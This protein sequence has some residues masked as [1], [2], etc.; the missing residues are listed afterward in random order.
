MPRIAQL[1]RVASEQSTYGIK[2]TFKD[3]D[4]VLLSASD[5]TSLHWWLTDTS[6][7]VIN[8]RSQIA[9]VSITNPY[10]VVLTNADLQILDKARGEE[11]RVVTLKGTYNST[12]G[13]DLVFTHAIGFSVINLLVIAQDLNISVVDHIFTGDFVDV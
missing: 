1:P 13:S 3:S 5:I 12:L 8:G 4:G 9:V 7:V 10:Y 2:L 6:G 11:R